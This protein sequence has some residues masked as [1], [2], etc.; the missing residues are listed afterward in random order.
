MLQLQRLSLLQAGQT[1]TVQAIHTDT[2]GFHFRL[3]ALGFRAGKELLVIRIAP[4]KGPM[5]LRLG[6][7]EVMLRQE[8]ANMI[9][10]L[11]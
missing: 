9:E 4:L 11:A 6:N 7:T 3:N 10:V 5:H 2:N 8:D 1:A